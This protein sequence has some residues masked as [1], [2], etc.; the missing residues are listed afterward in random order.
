[1]EH[2]RLIE[3]YFEDKLSNEQKTVFENLLDTDEK[4]RTQF[5]LEEQVKKAIISTKKDDLKEHLK[6]IEH[7][8]AN[9]KAT[10]YYKIAIVASLITCLSIVGIWKQNQPISNDALFAVYFQ[11]YDNIIV[12]NSRS[13]EIESPR[14]IAFRNYDTQNYKIASKQFADLYKNTSTSYYLFYQAICE[15]Q[16]GNTDKSI[17]LFNSHKQYSDNLSQHRNWYLALAYLKANDLEKSQK[18]LTQIISAK[19]Y[20]YKDAETILEKLD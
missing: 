3:L 16:L 14:V 15:L 17:D 19:A 2:K 6:Q 7:Q 11:P 1:M 20:K 18:I 12:P 13:N 9:K 8:Q 10:K 5:E 4:F